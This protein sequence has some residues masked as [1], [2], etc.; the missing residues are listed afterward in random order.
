MSENEKIEKNEK[1]EKMP[2]PFEK[3]IWFAVSI[4]VAVIGYFCRT[5]DVSFPWWGNALYAAFLIF[6]II[7]A[8]QKQS[9]E[10]F[11]YAEK[12]EDKIKYIISSI[13]YYFLICV[14]VFY[15]FYALWVSRVLSI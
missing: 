13:L 9:F 3:F 8:A 10:R 12:K 11:A 5:G 7:I 15:V 14:A 6:T 1:V 2:K 4:V